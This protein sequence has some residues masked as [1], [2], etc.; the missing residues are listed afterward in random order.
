MKIASKHVI[1][2]WSIKTPKHGCK[3]ISVNASVIRIRI[4]TI[5]KLKWEHKNVNLYK[6][7]CISN[8]I[9]VYHMSNKN[10]I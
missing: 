3:I 9:Y 10:C 8:T 2:T 6:H 7:E 4:Y 1:K 5:S